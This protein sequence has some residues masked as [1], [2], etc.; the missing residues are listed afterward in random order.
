MAAEL[1]KVRKTQMGATKPFW[2]PIDTEASDALPT[3]K[4]GMEF[5]E[6]IKLTEALQKAET[7]FYSN[8]AL[9]ENV[10]EFKYC[11]LTYDN[12]GLTNEVMAAV[13]GMTLAEDMLTYGA[14][15]TPPMGGLA[16]YRTLMDKGVKYYEGVFYPKVKASLGNAT[17][18]TKAENI[19]FQGDST[20]M[21]AY[22]CNDAA[23][24]WKQAKI[25]EAEAD[26]LAWVKTCLGITT[27]EEGA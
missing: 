18:D 22:Q 7:Q 5:S 2:A 23:K 21:I 26:A 16:F 24:T 12:K 17:Y 10:S 8:D 15:D 13:Y 25:F 1:S 11:E 19:T 20:S 3:Y 9:S 27:T 6:F 4:T 14:G